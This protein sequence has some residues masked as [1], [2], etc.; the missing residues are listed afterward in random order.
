MVASKGGEPAR[1]PR[2]TTA[3]TAS[4]GRTEG[5]R[6]IRRPRLFVAGF[7][8]LTS[9]LLSLPAPGRT[10]SR[11]VTDD[12]LLNAESDGANWL[13]Y[14]RTYNGWRYSPLAQIN[15][16]TIKRLVPKWI[17][18]GGAL[19]EQQMTPV[20]NDG[21]MFTTS[22]ALGWN[23][24]HALNAR[25]GEAL[26]RHERKIPEDVGALVR[27]IPHNR[28]V[29]LY[30]DR[31]IFGTL[32]AHLVALDAK[33]GA[34]V[35]ETKIA[36]YAD[37]YFVSQAPL[38]VKGKVV[39]GIAGPGEMG[40]RGFVEAFDAATGKS[41]WRWYSIPAAGEA[42]SET[43]SADTWKIGGGAVWHTGTYDPATNLLYV[44]TG[45][46]APWI[47]DM[48]RGDN[49][50]TMSAVAL[51]V[52]TGTLKWYHQ[53]LANEA[54]DFDTMAEHHVIDVV[55]NGQSHKAVVQ[56][57]KLGYVYTLDRING[58]F[59]S[60]APFVKSLTWG[61]P[62]PATG[63]GVEN[64]GLRPRMGGPPVEVCPSL[65]GATGWQPK[66]YNPK[67]GYLYIPSNE[68][69]MRY[70]Y[71]ADLTY[72]KGQLFTGVT[73]EHFSKAEQ[74]GVLRAFD[75]NQN[76]VVWEWSNRTPLISHTLSTAGDLVF[77][78]TPEGKVVA[79]NAKNGQ[80]LWSFSLG[81]PQSGGIMSYAVDGKQYLAVAA[82]GTLRSQVWFGK[83]PKW[84]NALKMNWSDLV[85]VFGLME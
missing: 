11:D 10:Q 60:A 4:E 72:K 79:L 53:Y 34:P 39:V 28:G 12:R 37:G 22:T 49:L 36:D 50:Y 85:V 83:E 73:T 2:V 55:R 23:R 31:V 27:V 9:L 7:L 6:M 70:A 58:K 32:D 18:A 25:T 43:W 41:L 67:T 56:A 77:Q 62:D 19:G 78:G 66:V 29:A 52:D 82:G 40:P 13:M 8:V 38:V 51:D 71:V 59:L 63:K 14:N 69:C 30:R 74:A 64:A 75:V 16:G 84:G 26:W 1:P 17:F 5:R 35:W 54:W 15:A 21:V 44:G 47:A 48:R 20:V 46:P 3:H 81:T 65:L 57:N 76:K 45:N 61:G 33:T 80:E 24:V 42:G 68:F